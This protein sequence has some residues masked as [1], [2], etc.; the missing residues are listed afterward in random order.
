[1]VGCFR[2]T[3]VLFVETGLTGLERPHNL[4]V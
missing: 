2:L 3:L 1:L 4:Y